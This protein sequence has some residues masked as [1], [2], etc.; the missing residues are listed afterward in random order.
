MN[1]ELLTVGTELLLGFTI[2]TNGAEIGRL[3]AAHGIRVV[4]RTSVPDDG[5]AIRDATDAALARTGALL[6]TGGL[7]PTRD[8]VTKHAVAGLMGMPLAFDDDVWAALEERFRKLGRTTPPSNRSQAMVPVGAT[9][10]PNRWGTAPGL[11][12]EN[13]RGI[14]V[15][16]PGVPMEM[17]NLL[18][19]EVL[20]RLVTRGGGLITLSRT[21]RTTSIAESALADRLAG[22]EDRIA[23]VTL[24]YL[25]GLEGVDLRLTAWQAMPDE[26]ARLLAEAIAKVKPLA[27][28]HVYGEDEEA[29]Q[30]VLLARLRHTG[31]TVAV[32][33]SCTG[34]CSGRGSPRCR[35]ARLRFSEAS[36]RTPTR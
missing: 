28:E 6:I 29:L 30:D 5:A 27:G 35:E 26:A 11:W 17:R 3:L 10:L 20:P 7:G 2:D 19:H 14:V 33:E 8:D 15:M 31:D 24:A 1:L 21:V 22:I 9:V 18:R 4:R 16:L 23:P 13:T 12:L 36:S 34:G 25:P 32:A